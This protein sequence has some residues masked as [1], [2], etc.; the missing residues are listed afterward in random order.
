MLRNFTLT[1]VVLLI[2][3]FTIFGRNGFLELVEF[4][5]QHSELQKKLASIKSSILREQ[6]TMYGLTNSP[7][8]LEQVAREDMALS[9]SGEVIYIFDP[10]LKKAELEKV[11][12]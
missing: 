2:A 3:F 7:E 11:N 1:I 8:Y 5:S 12:P 4:Q 6:N 10:S 9:K